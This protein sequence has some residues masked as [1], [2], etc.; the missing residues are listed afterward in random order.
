MCS[1]VPKK[2]T[3]CAFTADGRHMMAADKFGDVLVAA[4]DRPAGGAARL[5]GADAAA[6]ACRNARA[7]IAQLPS[8]PSCRSL[9]T[10]AG[11][12]EGREQEAQLLLGHYCAILTSLSLGGGGRLLATT[13]RHAHAGHAWATVAV[14]RRLK[15][16]GQHPPAPAP[17]HYCAAAASPRAGTTV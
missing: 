7:E 15:L 14:A 8:P 16:A 11:L 5:Q 9:S 1:K 2:V 6:A 12:E 17:P 4:T 13:D 10:H 3:T